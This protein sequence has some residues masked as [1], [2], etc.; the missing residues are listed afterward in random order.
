V[1]ADYGGVYTRGLVAWSALGGAVVVAGA[2]AFEGTPGALTAGAAM[3]AAGS[4]ATLALRLRSVARILAAP[5]KSQAGRSAYIHS[6]AKLAV[7]FA[8]MAAAV[9][10]GAAGAVGALLGL[11]TTP[12]AAVSEGVYTAVRGLGEQR[13]RRW[14]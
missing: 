2:A 7:A 8:V 6:L 1:N 11:L 13:R 9:Q 10:M 5:G 4:F 14:R 3:G 12:A